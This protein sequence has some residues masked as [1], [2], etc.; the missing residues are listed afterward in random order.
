[1]SK[2]L[3]INY[4]KIAIFGCKHTTLDLIKSLH[5]NPIKIDYC[6]TI[7]SK[8]AEEQKVSG[9]IDLKPYL[10]ELCIPIIY[11]TKYNLK[12]EEDKEKLSNLNLDLI[13]CIGWQRLLPEWLLSL[14]S[15]GA[16][17]MH[18]SN[19]PLPHGRGR[20]PLNWSLIQNKNIFFTHLF[21]YLPGVDD[22][23]ILAC[24]KFD[25]NFWDDS[26]SLHLKN[27]ISMAKL[28]K[29]SIPLLIEGNLISRPQPNIEPS[30]YPKR[31]KED[32]IIFWEDSVLDIYN[33][34]RAVT[35]PFPGAFS[36][37]ENNLNNEI[38]IW[39]AYPFDT[40]LEWDNSV[41]GEILE[42]FYDYSFI[43]QCGDGTLLVKEYDIKNKHLI[44]QGNML[45]SVNIKRKKFELPN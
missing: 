13:L 29:K 6:I 39:K 4:S 22:G 45:S 25:I 5:N 26:H 1:M 10:D 27:T 30:F 15:I 2:K 32:G 18:G 16:F 24:Q 8:K 41:N 40:R 9:Y 34:I 31:A 35:K 17:G 42:V 21:Q 23:P 44:K 14:L 20:S 3:H 36:Y 12:S 33:L 7:S 37:L 19:K 38:I 11:A 43:V 28:C